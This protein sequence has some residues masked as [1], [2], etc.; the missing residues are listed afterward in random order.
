[1][2]AIQDHIGSDSLNMMRRILVEE[3]ARREVG[4]D[5][6]MGQDLARVIMHAFQSGMTEESELVVLIRNLRD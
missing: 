1:M 3:C 4:P 2:L 5:H 6:S